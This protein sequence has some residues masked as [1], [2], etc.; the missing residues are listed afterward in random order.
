M[1]TSRLSKYARLNAVANGDIQRAAT[2]VTQSESPINL[3][4]SSLT[5]DNKNN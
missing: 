4:W 5:Q 1:F 2:Q 3:E